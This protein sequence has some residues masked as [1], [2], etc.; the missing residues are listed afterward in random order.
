MFEF[1][2]KGTDLD[3]LKSMGS[4]AGLVQVSRQVQGKHGMYTRK[5]WVRASDVQDTDKVVR[6]PDNPVSDREG[7]SRNDIEKSNHKAHMDSIDYQVGTVVTANVRDHRSGNYKPMRG[8]IVSTAFDVS[9]TKFRGVDQIDSTI[10]TIKDDKGKI[11]TLDLMHPKAKISRCNKKEAEEFLDRKV[12]DRRYFDKSANSADSLSFEEVCEKYNQEAPDRLTFD[13]YVRSKFFISDGYSQTKQVYKQKDGSYTPERQELHEA[14][15]DSIVE[16][17]DLPPEGE[18]PVC[19]LFGGGSASGKGS[20]VNPIMK[21]AA[22]SVGLNI[23]R[24]DSDE[25]KKDIPEY[26][27]MKEQNIDG[28]AFRVHDESSDIASMAT[29]R[30]IDEGRC[31]AFDGT[32]KNPVKYKAIIDKL[33]QNGYKVM[34][35]G[36]DIPT[37]EAIKRSDARAADPNGD[38]FGRKVPHGIIEG[39]HGG[40]AVTFPQLTSM[41]DD[42]Q[43]YDNSQ[44]QGEKPTLIC[45]KSGIQNDQLW[46]A[47]VKKGED[48]AKSKKE[49]K[50]HGK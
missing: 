15:I 31:F 40:F 47:F 20:V 32:M 27:Q 28:A 22:D 43:L 39:S 41:V 37:A 18:A 44:P 8:V 4:R 2:N 5:Q 29:D 24:V 21:A 36:V 10:V 1:V 23:G 9:Q 25:I 13:D 46:N 6:I 14:V 38:S 30:L 49:G 3:I 12:F 7:K 42:F 45:D 35:I 26:E 48:Y 19:Y 33:H 16:Q 17:C 50:K 34:I 11:H